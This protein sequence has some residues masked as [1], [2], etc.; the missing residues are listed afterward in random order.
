[1]TREQI[2]QLAHVRMQRWAAIV[3]RDAILPMLMIVTAPP[4][5]EY[6]LWLVSDED[7]SPY[8]AMA[9]FRKVAADLE[10][11]QHI[12]YLTGGGTP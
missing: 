10:A 8:E 4:D 2:R 7:L 5:Q 9:I 11:G 12:R 3:Q 1:M 6:G